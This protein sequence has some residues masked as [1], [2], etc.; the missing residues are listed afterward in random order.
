[1]HPGQ[2]AKGTFDCAEGRGGAGKPNRVTICRFFI[3]HLSFS[4]VIE[5][6]QLVQALSHRGGD[7]IKG[8]AAE[9]FDPLL[10]LKYAVQIAHIPYMSPKQAEGKPVD[11]RSDIFSFGSVRYEM[12]SRPRPFQGV[13]MVNLNLVE[14][15]VDIVS[16]V[17][18]DQDPDHTCHSIHR[19]TDGLLRLRPR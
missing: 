15:V 2:A 4:A 19:R 10:T 14:H 9:L 3:G 17:F 12:V 7:R 6:W 16:L 11:A 8:S 5:K 18:R 13:C 1:L